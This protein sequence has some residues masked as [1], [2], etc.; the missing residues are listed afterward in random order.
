[1]IEEALPIAV[2]QAQTRNPREVFS[3][4]SQKMREKVELTK[5]ER[6][7]ERAT[8]KRKIKNHLKHKELNKKE[9]RREMGV[10]LVADR[11][12]MK[13][14][15]RKQ[16]KKDKKKKGDSSGKGGADDKPLR[17]GSK[18]EMKSSKFFK[19]MEEV[20]KGDQAKKE[21]KKRSKLENTNSVYVNH[22]NKPT[23]RFKL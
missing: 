14:L 11:F 18:N 23:K 19:R 15:K 5:E 9:K 8:R 4:N 12:A 1:M 10:G 3:I 21:S 22:D 6:H 16:E 13:D 20:V 2:S 17:A 7:S